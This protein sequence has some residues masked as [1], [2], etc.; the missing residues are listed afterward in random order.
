M[1][2]FGISLFF[3]KFVNLPENHKTIIIMMPGMGKGWMESHDG[4]RV[5]EKN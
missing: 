4:I 5:E 2:F 1:D 3:S